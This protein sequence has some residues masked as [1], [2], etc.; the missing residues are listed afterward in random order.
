M[1]IEI[2]NGRVVDPAN[3][4]DLVQDVFIADGKVV[5]LDGIDLERPAEAGEA[6][7]GQLRLS[8]FF[9]KEAP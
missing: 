6:L 5:A 1:K 7:I 4:I 8:L 9:R 2:S 3:R